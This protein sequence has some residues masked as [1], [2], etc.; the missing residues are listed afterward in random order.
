VLARHSKKDTTNNPLN[1][2]RVTKNLQNHT[3][4]SQ[5]SMPVHID[6]FEAILSYM[7]ECGYIPTASDRFEWFLPSVT[8]TIYASAKTHCLTEQISGTLEWGNMVHLFN[9][10]CYQQYTHFLTAELQDKKKLTQNAVKMGQFSGNNT[11]VLHPESNHTTEQCKKLRDLKATTKP[12]YPLSGKRKGNP[13]GKGKGRE[14]GN[15]IPYD[16]PH[17]KAG[18]SAGSNPK[19]KGKGR[20]RGNGKDITCSHCH[21][22]GHEARDCFGY[23]GRYYTVLRNTPVIPEFF[24]VKIESVV[25][26]NGSPKQV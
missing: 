20:G 7:P 5:T 12:T 22:V 21:K 14:K 16:K 10:T 15:R 19:G 17:W 23:P 3:G 1:N 13:K 25:V 8:E 9:H 4:I 24:G 26:K 2:L 18:A 11:C 6:Q